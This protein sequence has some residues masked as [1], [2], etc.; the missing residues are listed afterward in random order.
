MQFID[1]HAHLNYNPLLKNHEA[2]IAE[3]LKSNVIKIIVV[4][5]DIQNSFAAIKLAEKFDNVY[6]AAG[7]HPHDIENAKEGWQKELERL[8]RHEK[9]VALGEIGLDYYR[10]YSPHDLQKKFFPAQIEM[11]RSMNLPMIIHNRAADDD[12]LDILQK[13][14]YTKGVMH[15]FGSDA[16]YAKKMVELGLMISF[17]G[18]I[19]YKNNKKGRQAVQ[20]TPIEKLMLETDC[21]FLSPEPRRGKTNQPANIPF[22]A[23]KVAELK[24][25]SIEEVAEITTENA[26][27]FFKLP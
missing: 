5:T 24:S 3:A 15:C 9:T 16:D 20:A 7:Y 4:G 6:A 26:N 12:T 25:L 21:P 27:R 2:V 10:N 14:G 11:A 8:L 17:T 1:T 22:I 18:N 19:T 13:T 23:D